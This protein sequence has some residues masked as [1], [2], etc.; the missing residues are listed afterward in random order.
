MKAWQFSLDD[1][2]VRGRENP[3]AN[4]L[5]T[6]P[7]AKADEAKAAHCQGNWA[8]EWGR[9]FAIDEQ[10]RLLP[11]AVAL[12]HLIP[13]DVGHRRVALN[14]TPAAV[15]D[16]GAFLPLREPQV[17]KQF[18]AGR[19]KQEHLTLRRA[20]TPLMISCYGARKPFLSDTHR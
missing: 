20:C 12:A 8:R 4:V 10:E 14:S 11:A 17:A 19:A 9:R 5:E 15:Q 13:L 18:E 2:L 1:F 3:A 16:E 6:F 7:A